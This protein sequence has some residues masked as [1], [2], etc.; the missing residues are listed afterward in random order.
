MGALAEICTVTF[1]LPAS[2]I[3]C[4]AFICN[5]KQMLDNSM[6]PQLLPVCCCPAPSPHP[7]AARIGQ[8]GLGS[9]SIIYVSGMK[10]SPWGSG[11]YKVWLQFKRPHKCPRKWKTLK[12]GKGKYTGNS[13]M[14]EQNNFGRRCLNKLV[15]LLL[16]MV[17]IYC[18]LEIS[19]SSP[20]FH[21]GGCIH[22]RVE[23]RVTS[24]FSFHL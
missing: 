4:P 10:P 1:V 13:F 6:A 8:C 14:Y 21:Q 3:D 12:E 16:K 20:Y 11:I 24:V 15:F 22:S 9:S 2:P 19:L 17:K 5:W 7:H 23:K 18:C